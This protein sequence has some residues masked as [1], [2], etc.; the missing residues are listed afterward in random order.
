MRRHPPWRGR[1]GAAPVAQRGLT[2]IE[3]VVAV[4]LLALLTLMSYRGL[5]SVTLAAEH[6]L[7]E[8]ERWRAVSMFFERLGADLAQATRR[9]VRGGDD[10]LLPELRGQ[11]VNLSGG[12]DQSANGDPITAQ[13]E[14]TR[15]SAPG[16][17]ELRLG[18]RLRQ[19][20]VELL[21]WR[22]LDRAP[23][24]TAEV[25]ALVDGVRSLRFSY[26]DSSGGWDEAW[27]INDN[28]QALPRA[29]AAELTLADGIVLHRVFALP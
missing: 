7:A 1:A 29:V 2:L 14:F 18:Y 3:L 22:V 20:R 24:S 8:G 17:D 26:L 23:A 15:K 10:T 9:P 12:S 16:S 13:L 11:M 25:H 28:R 27:P 6:T 4:A 19:E 21:I 5:A